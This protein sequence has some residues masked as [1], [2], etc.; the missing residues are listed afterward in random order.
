MSAERSLDTT[1]RT[2]LLDNS[3][4]IY[5]NLVKFER[6]EVSLADGS[7][8][9][10]YS[11]ITD[12]PYNIDYNGDTYIANKLISIGGVQESIE[13]RATTTSIKLS[14]LALGT[15]YSGTIN[16]NASNYIETD[17]DLAELG[18]CEGDKVHITGGTNDDKYVVIDSFQEASISDLPNSKI[19]VTP[20]NT[21]LSTASASTIILASE[22]LTALISNKEATSYANY[23]NREVYIYQAHLNPETGAIRGAPFTKFKGIISQGA[24]QEPTDGSATITWG[25][26]SHWGD[27]VRVQGRLTSDSSHRALSTSG[28]TDPDALVRD[29]Y[30]NDYGFMHSE[31]SVNVLATFQ[32]EELRYKMK[33]RGGLAGWLGGKKVVEYYETVDRDVDLRFNLSAKYLPV[34]YG[35]QKVSNIPVFAD[36]NAQ[37]PSEFYA[38]FALCEGEIGG[39]YDIYIDDESSICTDDMDIAVRGYSQVTDGSGEL[40]EDANVKVVCY[41]RADE[42]YVLAGDN[43]VDRTSPLDITYIDYTIPS[44]QQD[45]RD[46]IVWGWQPGT[47][48]LDKSFN[49]VGGGQ[50]G[51]SHETAYTFEVPIDASLMVHTGKPDQEANDVLVKIASDRNFKIQEDYYSGDPSDY[52]ST[53]HRLLDTAYV[54]GKFIL[55]EGEETIPDF[56]FVVKGKYVE[57]YNYDHSFKVMGGNPDDYDIG[58]IVSLTTNGDGGSHPGVQIIDKWTMYDREGNPDVRF[59]WRTNYPNTGDTLVDLGTTTT[60]I[61][62]TGSGSTIQMH[63]YDYYNGSGS[64]SDGPTSS[65]TGSTFTDT[66]GVASLTVSGISDPGVA[67]ILAAAGAN[68]AY[69]SLTNAPTNSFLVTSYAGGV[70]TLA[71]YSGAAAIFNNNSGSSIYVSNLVNGASGGSVG[72]IIDISRTINGVETTVRKRIKSSSGSYTFTESP[73]YPNFV[74]ASGDTYILGPAND[75]RVTINPAMQLLDYITSRRYGRGLTLSDLNL[76]SWLESGRLCDDQSKVV[77]VC[78]SAPTVGDIYRVSRGDGSLIFQ[79]TV[80]SV[81]SRSYSGT[82]YEV[83]FAD[84]IGKFGYKW[85]SWRSYLADDIVWGNDKVSVATSSGTLTETAFNALSSETSIGM[86]KVSG[87]GPATLSVTTSRLGGVKNTNSIV[88]SW[89]ELDQ[90]FSNPGYSLHD[91]DNVKYWKYVGWDEPEQRYVTRHQMNQV[92]NTNTPIFDNINSM[93]KQFNGILRYTNGLYELD[94]KTAAPPSFFD[95]INGISEDDIIGNIKID[96]KGSKNSYNSISANVIDP[97][98]KFSARSVSYF[99]STYLKEDR[100]VPKQGNYSLP[101]ISNYYASRTNV[102]QYLDESRYG[103]TISFTMDQKGYIL[104]TGK[105]IALTYSRF[106]WVEKLFRITSI[107]MLSNGLVGIVADEHNNDAYLIDYAD[108]DLSYNPGTGASAITLE[109]PINLAASQDLD[110]AIQLTW[111]NAI[112]YEPNTYNIEIWAAEATKDSLGNLVLDSNS[113]P[114]G[115]D[116]NNAAFL[117]LGNGVNY[118]HNGLGEVTGENDS[119]HVWYYWIRYAKPPKNTRGII[120]YSV[121]EPLSTE[122]GVEGRATDALADNGRTVALTSDRYVWEYDDDNNLIGSPSAVEATVTATPFNHIGTPYYQFFVYDV[123]GNLEITS[124]ATPETGNTYTY[125][126]PLDY[127]PTSADPRGMPETIKVEMREGDAANPLEAIDTLVFYGLSETSEALTSSLSNPNHNMYVAPTG[128]VNYT[129]SGTT[130]EVLEGDL[131]LTAVDTVDLDPGQYKVVVESATD[132]NPGTIA[133]DGTGTLMVVSDHSGMTADTANIVYDIVVQRTSGREV[134]LNRTQYFTKVKDGV[135]G[136]STKLLPSDSSV[137][138]DAEGANPVFS[139]NSAGNI[140]LLAT[141]EGYTDPYYR[142]IQDG[143]PGAWTQANSDLSY[144]FEYTPPSAYTLGTTVFELETREGPSGSATSA[145]NVSI[146]FVKE[147]EGGLAGILTNENHT[148]PCLEDGT[149]YDLADAGGTFE[150]FSGGTEVTDQCTFT[151]DAIQNGLSLNIVESGVTAGQYTLS[152]ASWTSDLEVFTLQATYDGSTI[153]KKYTIS[154]A[155]AGSSG[156]TV[157]LYANDYTI[158]Y[159]D[160][161]GQPNPSTGTVTLTAEAF[162]LTVP[163]FKFSTTFSTITNT[164]Y[165][166]GNTALWTIPPDGNTFNSPCTITVTAREQGTTSP[167]YTDK[168]TIHAAKDNTGAF[169][170]VIT[171]PTQGLSEV[172]G[173]IDYDSSDTYIT[174]Y[175]GATQLDFTKDISLSNLAGSTLNKWRINST[176]YAGGIS[177]ASPSN[178]EAADYPNTDDSAYVWELV[179]GAWTNTI[180]YTGYREFEIQIQ[181]ENQTSGFTTIDVR[182][183]FTRNVAGGD[184]TDAYTV[185]LS[186]NAHAVPTNDN[187]TSPD[188]TNSGTDITVFKGDTQLDYATF[189]NDKFSVG[190]PSSGTDV[191]PS[192]PSTISGN[193]RRFPNHTFEDPLSV[194]TT[195]ID[196]PVTIVDTDGNTIGPID[197]RQTFTRVPAGEDGI[198]VGFEPA[199]ATISTD[200]AGEPSYYD[201]ATGVIETPT[202]ATRYWYMK[203]YS[204]GVDVSSSATYDLPNGAYFDST[205]D[206]ELKSS[207]LALFMNRSN[208]TMLLAVDTDNDLWT[209]S[210]E[211]FTCR[212]TYGGTNYDITFSVS[213]AADGSAGSSGGGLCVV[214]GGNVG[215]SGSTNVTARWIFSNNGTEYSKQNNLGQVPRGSWLVSGSASDYEIY[216]T[217]VEEVTEGTT[218]STGTFNSWLSLGSDRYWEVAAPGTGAEIT[219]RIQFTI[220]KISDSST[221]AVGFANITATDIA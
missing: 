19:N 4:Y 152:G 196:Y 110:G 96:D 176:T 25:L 64:V 45:V 164:V 93:L 198:S 36:V 217:L 94:I 95:G 47:P 101:G 178:I 202:G 168:V 91:S 212:A 208:G 154:K 41:G 60:V 114:T 194:A 150:V 120:Q 171:N 190:T 185:V 9:P 104:L 109:A 186:N 89:S 105:I 31:K 59:R 149:G 38:A 100:G 39:I 13:A 122:L 56:E 106:N 50:I 28:S 85:N 35:V 111:T 133:P 7:V 12:A 137:V 78:T 80:E 197:Y 108:R 99:N 214:N 102:I 221:Q 199:S 77:V 1:L 98:N 11:Y 57:C 42:G 153:T 20:V 86:S 40:L 65:F 181:R 21:T 157:M 170:V 169:T 160:Q 75:E 49:T 119:F 117:D 141:A 123:Q 147:G 16:V 138:Y 166:T 215:Y 37:D 5:I 163:E 15:A 126:P 58:D 2:S 71:A 68:T 189:G 175:E 63:T 180:L 22:E 69:I 53:S 79:G 131:P 200:N 51:L 218:S 184:G 206:R 127:D 179:N 81:T 18:F 70:A 183:S 124:P 67:A 90:A 219:Q 220:R 148:E 92:V 66:N 103:L 174:V 135:D 128:V 144:T 207:D 10:S 29:E 46:G 115:N 97:Q 211:S 26:T 140:E 146:L 112:S 192:T 205:Y 151:G 3:P 209:S 61:T 48:Q 87:A 107:T 136:R 118:V 162:G 191:T 17:V 173:I 62:M 76:D 203:V 142:L 161:G 139:G 74:P 213:R 156:A 158:L 52:W 155:K 195:Y 23:L 210:E 54:V 134:T 187:Y 73:F 132:I 121:F 216:A 44:W 145:D 167:E 33:K 8:D 55:S 34:V 130:I 125:T 14:S 30:A 72:E 188:N 165:S 159:D 204:G 129:G 83:E 113:D 143:S 182:Q 24:L 32:A 88:R 6:P 43:Y 84:C 201:T 116:F 82:W 177:G 193:I 172:G 27:F